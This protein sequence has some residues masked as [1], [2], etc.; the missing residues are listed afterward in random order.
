MSLVINNFFN[1]VSE[2]QSR[3]RRMIVK[4]RTWSGLVAHA[5][6]NA[7][8]RVAGIPIQFLTT[9]HE[10]QRREIEC[11]RLLNDRRQA[12]TYGGNRV[13]VERLPGEDL[14]AQ[15]SRGTLTRRMIEAAAREFRRAHKMWSSDFD[16]LWSHGDG[17]MSNVIF[18]PAAG[19]ARLIDFEIMHDKSLPARRRHADDLAVFLLDLVT[20]APNRSWLALSLSFVQAYGEPLVIEELRNMLRPPRGLAF[21]WWRVRTNFVNTRHLLRRLARLRKAMDHFQI[22]RSL[23]THESFAGAPRGC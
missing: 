14:L 20:M 2:F 17:T 12:A 23:E 4:T 1:G 11:F 9:N 21:I 7:F 16:D 6:A 22:E 5:M 19:R 8:F 13:C 10:W 3:R 15:V 18:D